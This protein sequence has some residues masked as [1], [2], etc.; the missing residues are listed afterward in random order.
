MMPLL[1]Q[2]LM[3]NF[4]GLGTLTALLCGMIRLQLRRLA[5]H[6]PGDAPQS[7]CGIPGRNYSR[8]AVQ[9]HQGTMRHTRSRRTGYCSGASPWEDSVRPLLH[10]RLLPTAMHCNY[11]SLVGSRNLKSEALIVP[12]G[13]PTPACPALGPCSRYLSRFLQ[14]PCCTSLT[15]PIYASLRPLLSCAVGLLRRVGVRQCGRGYG[16]C[17]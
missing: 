3:R 15:L 13:V 16:R 1:V 11:M 8:T 6:R 2:S 7:H 4:H 9:P 14:Q 10:Q 12:L 17:H 5:A